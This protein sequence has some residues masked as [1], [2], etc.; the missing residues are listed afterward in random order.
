MHATFPHEPVA[1]SKA[2]TKELMTYQHVHKNIQNK[3]K[4]VLIDQHVNVKQ[5]V[6]MQLHKFRWC[7]Y[8]QKVIYVCIIYYKQ[9]QY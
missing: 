7:S 6:A 4:L 2:S 3:H 1:E 8:Y 9:H 5:A